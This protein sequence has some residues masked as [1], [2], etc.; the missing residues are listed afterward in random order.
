M[1]LPT[2]SDYYFDEFR[3]NII[4]INPADNW[5]LSSFTPNNISTSKLVVIARKAEPAYLNWSAYMYVYSSFNSSESPSL[6]SGAT[7]RGVA[8]KSSK[9]SNY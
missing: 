3:T 5:L 9:L 1:F 8:I 2:V 7:E 4:I 6:S